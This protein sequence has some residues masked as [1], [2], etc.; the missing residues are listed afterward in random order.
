MCLGSVMGRHYAGKNIRVKRKN[1]LTDDILG[2][3]FLPCPALVPKAKKR[4]A[5]MS[6][7]VAT[8]AEAKAVAAE[9]EEIFGDCDYVVRIIRP[10]FPGD[11]YTVTMGV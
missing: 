9:W 5:P 3:L 4:K 2:V 7:R 6:K 1:I 11:F 8:L 10:Y